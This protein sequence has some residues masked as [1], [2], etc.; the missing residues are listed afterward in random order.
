MPFHGIAYP[1]GL[2]KGLHPRDVLF[3]I[4]NGLASWPSTKLFAHVGA[5]AQ[6]L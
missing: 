3:T 2:T 6:H 1:K 5:I 4:A